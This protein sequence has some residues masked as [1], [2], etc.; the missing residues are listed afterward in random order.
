MEVSDEEDTDN[1]EL[2]M[3]DMVVSHA[4]PAQGSRAPEVTTTTSKLWEGSLKVILDQKNFYNVVRVALFSLHLLVV[5]SL[6][7]TT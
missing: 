4:Q 1:E 7:S 5:H 2:H 3:G 6:W